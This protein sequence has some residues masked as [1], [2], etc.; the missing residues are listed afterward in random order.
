MTTVDSYSDAKTARLY[1]VDELLRSPQGGTYEEMLQ[2]VNDWPDDIKQRFHVIRGFLDLYETKK[3]EWDLMEKT[4]EWLVEIYAFSHGISIPSATKG[5]RLVKKQ[6][7]E[8]FIIEEQKRKGLEKRFRYIDPTYSVFGSGDYAAYMENKDKPIVIVRRKDKAIKTPKALKDF[9][10]RLLDEGRVQTTAFVKSNM[11]QLQA[12]ISMD[13]RYLTDKVPQELELSIAFANSR[14][15]PLDGI[16]QAQL[17]FIRALYFIQHQRFANALTNLRK[18]LALC[19]K[20][21]KN[22]IAR[23]LLKEAEALV[24]SIQF[25]E[26]V[27]V[28][29]E[30]AVSKWPKVSR[31]ALGKQQQKRYLRLSFIHSDV[32]GIKVSYMGVP[33]GF[34]RPRGLVGKKRG[35]RW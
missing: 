16:Q 29:F 7:R 33:T 13:P 26:P 9:Q 17:Y 34:H 5:S 20:Y 30:R 19:S 14:H 25:G 15:F 11:S 24:H 28:S 2:R 21:P 32:L 1:V 8:Q 3:P 31:M 10:R 4:I 23:Q 22:E 6:T 18:V 35:F 27:E 12:K